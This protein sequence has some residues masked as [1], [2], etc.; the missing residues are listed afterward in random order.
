MSRHPKFGASAS[1]VGDTKPGSPTP[2]PRNRAPSG[3][4]PSNRVWASRAASAIVSSGALSAKSRSIRRCPSSR[5]ARS[6]S[7]TSRLATSTSTPRATALPSAGVRRLAG[8]P[9]PPPSPG[10][11][12]RTSPA[13]TRSST[14]REIVARVIPV[15][16]ERPARV[17]SPGE[18]RMLRST[19]DMLDARTFSDFTPR[20]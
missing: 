17:T 19:V 9:R 15:R 20:F 8:R 4:V 14:R 7:M 18:A 16:C 12:S 10:S 3:R 6:T 13:P 1:R 11:S 5:P 2:V